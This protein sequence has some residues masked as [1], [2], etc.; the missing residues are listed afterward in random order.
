MAHDGQTLVARVGAQLAPYVRSETEQRIL[1]DAALYGFDSA[2][3]KVLLS[4]SGI[5][6]GVACA[7][8]L[9]GH[10]TLHDGTHPLVRV[11]ETQRDWLGEGLETR[12]PWDAL[13]AEVQRHAR[14]APIAT[15]RRMAELAY[16]ADLR[17]R[18]DPRYVLNDDEAPYIELSGESHVRMTPR[19]PRRKQGLVRDVG[20]VFTHERAKPEHFETESKPFPDAVTRI[21]ELRQAALLG[22]P[23]AGKSTVMAA[24]TKQLMAKAEAD[25]AQPLPMLVDLARWTAPR[26][27]LEAFIASQLG[28]HAL[29]LAEALTSGRAALLLDSMNE[30]PSAQRE[31]K[32]EQVQALLAAQK[33]AHPKTIA[34]VSCRREDYRD[35]GFDRIII[36]P[37][38][39][40]QIR[41]FAQAY[42][43]DPED[44][45]AL[46]WKLAGEAAR[47]VERECGAAW[48]QIH[49]DWRKALWV[50]RVPRT[51]YEWLYFGSYPRWEGW[52]A[53][54]DAARGLL[55]LASNPYL[56]QQLIG[57]YHDGHGEL[58][59]NR[60]QLFES[61][62][63][64]LLKREK[65]DV[66]LRV[67]FATQLAVL[68]FAMQTQPDA[69]AT[70]G[71]GAGT[72]LG[73]VQALE[74][75]S[76]DDLKL[77]QRAS[78]IDASEQ[79]RFTHQLLQEY[80]VARHMQTEIDAGR[81]HAETLWPP[82]NWWARNA[83]EEA[84]LL[85]AG[86]HTQG[87]GAVVNW[88]MDAQPEMAARCIAE[89]GAGALDD[90]DLHDLRARWLPRLDPAHEPKAQ[91]R[92]AVGR[93]LGLVRLSTGE[94]LDDRPGV[95]VN[96]QSGLPDIDW[97]PIPGGPF[98]YGED[99]TQTTQNLPAF[100]IARYPVTYA[101]YQCFLDAGDGWRD[102]RWWQGLSA[103]DD[104]RNTTD[105]QA[106][107]YWNHPRETVSWYDAVAFCRW[108]SA[109]LGYTVTL[110]SEQQFER[111]ARF[112]D[113]RAYPWGDD[114]RAGHANTDS[115]KDPIGKTTAVGLYPAGASV[116]GVCDL[117]GN[118]WEWCRNEHSNPERMQ[119]AGGEAR[120]V[121]GGSWDVSSL[122]ARAAYRG[123]NLPFVRFNDFGF[124]LVC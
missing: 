65:L 46:F 47:A 111:A 78:L 58:P 24:L 106:F 21:Q 9:L 96:V 85:L 40:L 109:R 100:K 13:I 122:N 31:D 121:R 48:S 2:R 29:L 105:E 11:L 37:L 94:L 34:V 6:F 108:L 55:K 28:R 67:A 73:K 99:T 91:A 88:L 36:Q 61:F 15:A 74:H 87:L 35:L 93:A 82:E 117:S 23:G 102:K 76:M 4:Q 104:E 14:V 66:H 112:T 20:L 33:T 19:R 16:L 38:N 69:H 98:I 92:A 51:N 89:A 18:H 70:E 107:K 119:D 113:G 114:Y 101:Q 42:F 12:A 27:S 124:R 81:L 3:N 84:T 95:G 79:V 8:V 22:E 83:W 49:A 5:G 116:E 43:E 68:A 63:D 54:R 56:L 62:V 26:Q 118:V 10:G 90:K 41:R 57:K 80:F 75:L 115:E 52:I 50:D 110:P 39:A 1:L 120:V 71:Q 86:S 32:Y 60:G 7:S 72:V 64:G 59:A 97:E 123:N 17:T 103:D 25:A 30:I 53:Q 44:G 45:E 77:A